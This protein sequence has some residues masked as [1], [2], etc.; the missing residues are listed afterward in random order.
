MP[1]SVLVTN[2]SEILLRTKSEGEV[3]AL[4]PNANGVEQEVTSVPADLYRLVN[5]LM[6]ALKW[7]S[8][9]RTGLSGPWYPTASEM[10]GISGWWF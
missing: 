3:C 10:W 9:L 2:E 8:G 5:T 7:T 6:R 1:G 4:G